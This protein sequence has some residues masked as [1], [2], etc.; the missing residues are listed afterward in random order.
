MTRWAA[1]ASDH[2]D[3]VV[4][5]DEIRAKIRAN[6]ERLETQRSGVIGTQ[7]GVVEDEL[8][9]LIA[10]LADGEV[11]SGVALE[12]LEPL[13]RCRRM[14]D[15]AW[16]DLLELVD[17]SGQT[18][19]T[20]GLT[21]RSY[22]SG[23]LGSDTVTAGRETLNGRTLSRFVA[24]ERA[25]RSGTITMDHIT[26]LRVVSNPRNID[27]LEQV[28][29]A[30]VEL[31]RNLSFTRW[32]QELTAIAHQLDTDG[33]EPSEPKPNTGRLTRHHDG[34]VELSVEFNGVDGASINEMIEARI[35]ALIASQNDARAQGRGAGSE[36][37][38]VRGELV[39]DA[40]EEL[41]RAGHVSLTTGGD[42]AKQPRTDLS[43]VLRSHP[44]SDM[45]DY[46]GLGD[47]TPSVEALDS[48]GVK[49]S[50]LQLASRIENAYVRVL[51]ENAQGAVTHLVKN[52]RLA[53]ADQ[54]AAVRG[55]D[56]GCAF[57]GCEAP[58]A[59]TQTH[60]YIRHADGGET[61]V[62]NLGPFCQRHHTV[63]H[64]PGWSTQPHPDH[65]QTWIITTPTGQ[66]HI[67]QR[68]GRQPKPPPG[69]AASGTAPPGVDPPGL[70]S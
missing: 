70:A 15:A 34:G 42:I 51:I 36:H 39:A 5:L 14:L 33:V 59:W 58:A 68:Y 38:R 16:L 21:T 20:R 60:H 43:V 45:F 66:Q 57:P 4:F 69:T 17:R 28:E 55:R 12:L 52:A 19:I 23:V 3:D 62:N 2:H 67:T 24:F 41:I 47:C 25:F 32:K 6:I 22:L 35:S 27:A 13:S 64:S 48:F 50:P 9:S 18:M 44:H 63:V 61:G 29:D 37:R 11:A 31:A 26:A 30:L 54:R 7:I 65:D 10:Q 53:T 56:G 46:L 1:G 40:V 49:L 8:E